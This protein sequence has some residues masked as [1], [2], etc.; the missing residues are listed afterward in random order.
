MCNVVGL[1]LLGLGK[2]PLKIFLIFS[3]IG[4]VMF[5][6]SRI[7]TALIKPIY[8]VM[9]LLTFPIGWVVSHLVIGLFYYGIITP[10][11]I[12]FKIL[13]RDPLS[14]KYDHQLNTYW[15]PYKHKRSAKDYFHQF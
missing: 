6:L 12:V 9:V 10:V 11:A 4:I 14:R 5:I 1:L 8:L 13:G 7:S 2:I 15:I 3:L